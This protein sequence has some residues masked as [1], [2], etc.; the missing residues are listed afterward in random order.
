MNVIWNKQDSSR[1]DINGTRTEHQ[2][3]YHCMLVAVLSKLLCS[4]VVAIGC[5][6][7]PPTHRQS[8]ISASVSS[9]CLRAT[10]THL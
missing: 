7:L 8:Y 10:A 9:R 4:L 5:D 6:W 2:I 3:L 1:K